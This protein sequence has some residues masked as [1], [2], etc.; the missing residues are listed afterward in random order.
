M[1]S[2]VSSAAENMLAARHP[3]PHPALHQRRSFFSQGRVHVEL[4][5]Q[6]PADFVE[7][8]QRLPKHRQLGWQPNAVLPAVRDIS[9][10]TRP[11]CS[12]ARATSE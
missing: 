6:R 9:I 11:T 1:N 4:G 3:V 10:I 8:Q 12:S 7:I 5:R 2:F